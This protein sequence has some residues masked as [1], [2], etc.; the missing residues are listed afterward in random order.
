MLLLLFSTLFIM[1]K[2]PIGELPV[3]DF[4]SL[5]VI[6]AIV[7]AD[8]A[9]SS[10]KHLPTAVAVVALALLQRLITQLMIKYRKIN[11]LFT[12]EPTIVVT[13]G[14]FI[15]KNIKKIKYTIEEVLMLLRDKNI[16]DISQLEYAV[17]EPNGRISVLKKAGYEPVVKKDLNI[18]TNETDVQ[19]VV[20]LEREIIKESLSYINITED[21]LL[22]ILNQNGYKNY[23]ELFIVTLSKN[24]SISISPYTVKEDIILR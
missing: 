9:D 4:L 16:F 15:H 11:K 19:V 3:F 13:N 20:V 23:Q 6:G 10:I 22:S 14:K 5:V 18:I 12:F 7:G 17:I 8:I 21:E 24:R 1:G 2:R